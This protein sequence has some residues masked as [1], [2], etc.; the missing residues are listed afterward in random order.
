[1]NQ[2][3]IQKLV[4][5][6]VTDLQALF[7]QSAIAALTN[8]GNGN[9]HGKLKSNG[10]NGMRGAKR[11]PEDLQRLSEEFLAYV[12]KN[13]GLRI[14]QINKEIGATTKDL[15]LPIRKLIADKRLKMKGKKRSTT[16]YAV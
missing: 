7:Q 3:N 10:L 16:Y 9:G 13:P 11:A 5:N 1:M 14:E 8:A 6:F 2:T 12:L 15:A 4:S